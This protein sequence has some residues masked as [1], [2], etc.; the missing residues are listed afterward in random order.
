MSSDSRT[1][2][3]WMV[4]VGLLLAGTVWFFTRPRDD[5]ENTPPGIR[6]V[7]KLEDKRDTK[8]LGAKVSDADPQVASRAAQALGRI[9]GDEA[10]RQIVPAFQDARPQIRA[11]AATSYGN[12]ASPDNA[13]PVSNLLANDRDG[14]VRAAAAESLGRMRAYNGMD[15]LLKGLDDPEVDVRRASIGA[16]ENILPGL[17]WRYVPDAPD[18]ERR[19][20]IAEIRQAYPKLK[21]NY[22]RYMEQLKQQGKQ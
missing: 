1:R 16:I 15:A 6:N 3:V 18:A 11:V 2:L 20:A 21:G 4:S 5:D 10:A 14:E 13:A 19:A 7:N 8:A 12:A 17:K 22:D 9:G